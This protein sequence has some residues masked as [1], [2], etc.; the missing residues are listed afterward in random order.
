MP[1][2]LVAWLFGHQGYVSGQTLCLR[3][4]TLEAIGGL[5]QIVNHLADDHRLGELV[6]GL[7]MRIVL[8][9]YVLKAEHHEPDFASLM[10]HERRWMRTL[11]ALRPRSFGLL[12]LT[13]S[14]PVAVA[15]A[16]LGASEPPMVTTAWGLVAITAAARCLLYVMPRLREDGTLHRDLWLLPARDLLLCCVWCR[17]LFTSRIVWR[18]SEFAVDADGLLRRL[19]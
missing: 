15:A 10:S 12:F 7:G 11:R 4:D 9:T 13:F 18:G 5:R 16:L 2:V 19:S 3:R 8:S 14:L 17:S 1:S 6:R